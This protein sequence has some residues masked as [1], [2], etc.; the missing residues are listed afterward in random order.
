MLWA[1]STHSLAFPRDVNVSVL[2]AKND[3]CQRN[4]N[5]IL[6]IISLFYQYHN[7]NFS[8]LFL[9][10]KMLAMCILTLF[11]VFYEL[12]VPPQYPLSLS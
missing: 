8:L 5:R 10:I 4:L 7:V 2:P 9:H 12:L 3:S 6:E 1:E 11:Y